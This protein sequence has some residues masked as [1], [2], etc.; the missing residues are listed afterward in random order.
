VKLR[1]RYYRIRKGLTQGELAEKVGRTEAAINRLEKH[2]TSPQMETLRKLAEVLE[3]S[4]DDLIIEDDEEE[5]NEE[6]K[7]LLKVG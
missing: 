3:V 4:I 1:L 6:T 7:D 2:R 5:K